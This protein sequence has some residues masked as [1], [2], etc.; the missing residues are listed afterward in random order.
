V[1]PR[2]LNVVPTKCISQDSD[3]ENLWYRHR[4]A[5]A[6]LSINQSII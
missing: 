2:Q 1:S 4:P 6:H 5:L 3:R